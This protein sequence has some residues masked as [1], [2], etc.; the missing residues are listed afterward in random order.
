MQRHKT[1]YL[2][3][4]IFAILA[5]LLS[6]CASSNQPP[7]TKLG[8][9]Q[10]SS[11][12]PPRATLTLHPDTILIPEFSP[13]NSD[14]FQST[15][16]MFVTSPPIKSPS[17]TN[18]HCPPSEIDQYLDIVLPLADEHTID[19]YEAQKMEVLKD[20]S[21]IVALRDKAII[22]LKSIQG[23]QAPSCLIVAHEKMTESFELLVSTWDLIRVK[24]YSTATT[25]LQQ[26]YEAL[27]EAVAMITIIQQE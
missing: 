19:T 10:P 22:R 1:S 8:F 20:E 21:H 16:T 4:P 27:A 5:L 6:A 13:T 26:C 14:T 12:T 15:A 18:A 24:D 23:I 9:T 2:Q 17:S 25:T 7:T 3:Y 11:N